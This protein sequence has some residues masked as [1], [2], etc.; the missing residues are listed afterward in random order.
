MSNFVKVKYDDGYKEEVIAVFDNPVKAEEFIKKRKSDSKKL[1]KEETRTFDGELSKIKHNQ[2]L[3]FR[4]EK[5]FYEDGTTR[6]EV[7][8]DRSSDLDTDLLVTKGSRVPKNM[9]YNEE[10]DYIS[11]KGVVR[12]RSRKKAIRILNKFIY[13]FNN[14]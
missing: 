8:W 1:Y 7:N 5:T 4:V 11:F 12:S 2:P 10:M 14:W 13:E 6:K 3:V 9:V